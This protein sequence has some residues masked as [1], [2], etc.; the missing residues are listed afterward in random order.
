M[1][2]PVATA[3]FNCFQDL[4]VMPRVT[5]SFH[6]WQSLMMLAVQL[7]MLNKILKKSAR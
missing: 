2:V 7:L 4:P 3:K 1:D 5:F 6:S